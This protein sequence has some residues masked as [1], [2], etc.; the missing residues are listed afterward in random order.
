MPSVATPQRHVKE[1]YTK[2]P[3]NYAEEIVH[4][5]MKSCTGVPVYRVDIKTKSNKGNGSRGCCTEC[6]MQTNTFAL[7]AKGGSV[8]L[9]WYQKDRKR[10]VAKSTNS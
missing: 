5:R 7:F 2:N 8:T 1:W 3:R 9:S 6:N 4:S 10:M